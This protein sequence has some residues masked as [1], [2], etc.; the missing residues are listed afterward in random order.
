DRARHA[1]LGGA[2]RER[3]LQR[4][5]EI[6]AQVAAAVL[7]PS[8]LAAAAE[9]AE[10]VLEDVAE[11]G[12]EIERIALRP[13]AALLEG[14]MAEAVIGGALLL[15]LQ[16]VIGFVDFLELDLGGVVARI[17]VRVQLHRELAERR[18]DLGRRRAFLQAE[19]VVVVAF[20]H[21]PAG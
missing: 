16:D 1:D 7:A 21:R 13:S 15:V 5:L 10:Q 9:L 12:R 18:L 14:G 19:Y 8:L 4:D 17:L 3:F 11:G 6:V 2:S 20:A